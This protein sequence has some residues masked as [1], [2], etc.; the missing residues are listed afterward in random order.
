MSELT[1]AGR[2]VIADLANRYGLTLQ[3]VEAMAHAVAQGGGTM[4]QFNVA[5]LG[6]SG[7]WMAG[8]MTMVGNMFDHGLQARVSNLC[9]DLSNAMATTEFFAHAHGGM[10]ASWWPEELGQPSASGGQNQVRYAYF[11]QQQRVAFDPGTGAPVI[12]L[13]SGDHQIGG[14]SQQQ[15]G[16][17]DPFAGI[18]FSSQFGQFSLASLPQI[19]SSGMVAGQSSPSPVVEPAPVP[20]RDD[21]AG[22]DAPMPAPEMAP[23]ESNSATLAAGPSGAN[24]DELLATIERLAALHQAGVLTDDEFAQKKSELLA[25][26]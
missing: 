17:G 5:E 9:G 24:V 22:S 16:P 18:A 21:V 4:A 12:L 13:D 25:R 26:I 8:G 15:S 3:S 23:T 10:S 6:G 20:A 11:P 14:F 19:H 1:Q 7:Q 2:Q